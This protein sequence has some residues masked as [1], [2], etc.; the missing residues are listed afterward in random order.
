MVEGRGSASFGAHRSSRVFASRIQLRLQLRALEA[1]FNYACGLSLDESSLG[2]MATWAATG[3]A[4]PRDSQHALGRVWAMGDKFS[5]SES[6]T[7]LESGA[8]RR[9]RG[10]RALCAFDHVHM[11]Y[12]RRESSSSST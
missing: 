8:T 10:S 6:G 9:S 1:F 2:R 3:Q 11:A 5:A 7:T 4:G 12:G